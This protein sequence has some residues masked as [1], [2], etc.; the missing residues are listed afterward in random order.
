MAL[1]LRRSDDALR[2]RRR[3]CYGSGDCRR[4]WRQ[5]FCDGRR[6]WRRHGQ[7]IDG[8]LGHD[9][10]RCRRRQARTNRRP[11]DRCRG[12]WRLRGRIHGRRKPGST[13][14]G[15][16][17]DQVRCRYWRSGRVQNHSLAPRRGDDAL[18]VSVDVLVAV[19]V[20]VSVAVFEAE[21]FPMLAPLRSMT[22]GRRT[23]RHQLVHQSVPGVDDVAGV[24]TG[25]D[26]TGVVGVTAG[27]VVD[28]GVVAGVWAVCPKPPCHLGSFGFMSPV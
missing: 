20:A 8:R 26:V 2:G 24:V 10:R 9:R 3:R 7:A 1:P 4:R 17:S 28:A 5:W 15:R 16:R 14:S 19:F 13:G 18:D 27:V 21:G 25:D 22:Y 12:H 23:I 11:C 6:R